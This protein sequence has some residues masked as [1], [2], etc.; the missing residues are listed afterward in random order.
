MIKSEKGRKVN[1]IYITPKADISSKSYKDE[2]DKLVRE[3]KLPEGYY[4]EWAGQSQ[5]LESAMDRLVYIIPA[6]FVIIFI[7]I[8]FALRNFI[9]AMIVFLTLPFALI[10]GLWY[11]D[12]LNFN[13]SIAVVVGFL[14]LLGIAAETA[15]VM[16]VYL[17][18]AVVEKENRVGK[19]D[20]LALKAAVIE[21]AALRLRPKLMTVF[22]ILGGLFPIVYLEG[23]GSEVM[24]RIAVPMI[25][26]MISSTV[27][28]LIIIPVLFYVSKQ[29]ILSK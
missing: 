3:L 2:A 12:F 27:L 23:V 9:Y 5:Y 20:Q 14:A 7:L 26:G 18:E 6:T 28:T 15:I 8:Y 17:D 19:L 4:Y 24:Q 22:A 1:F 21:G 11:V 29:S 25:G 13:I 16:M 10:G